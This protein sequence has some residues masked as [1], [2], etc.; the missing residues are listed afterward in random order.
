MKKFSYIIFVAIA[1]ILI[2]S[3]CSFAQKVNG[4]ILFESDSVDVMLKIPFG[5]GFFNRKIY[6]MQFK[7]KYI[8]HKGDK[9]EL[10]PDQAKEIRF[11]LWGESVRLISKKDRFGLK[12]KK[13]KNV[14]IRIL[15][16][17]KLKLY[18]VHQLL[19][20]NL[21]VS[22]YY[23]QKNNDRS[24]CAGVTEFHSYIS[25]YFG[26]CPELSDKIKAKAY[27]LRDIFEIVEFYN[28]NCATE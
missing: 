16:D 12:P 7:V 2:N 6:R 28:M 23:L 27:R 21:I 17:D 13:T 14:F 26:D 20:D 18:Q 5:Y 22:P 11:K 15:V 9:K 10:N 19:R 3:T 4:K 24:T 25:A 1:I 8:D